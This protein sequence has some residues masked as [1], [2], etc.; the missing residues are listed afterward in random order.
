[1]PTHTGLVAWLGEWLHPFVNGLT[2]TEAVTVLQPLAL[3][4]LVMAA[5]AVFV[6]ELYHFISDKDIFDLSFRQYARG[7]T[8]KM[9]NVFRGLLYV[10][11][12]LVVYPLLVVIW[13]LVFAGFLSFLAKG[14]TTNTLLLAS[15]AFVSTVRIAA[16]YHK[17]LAE[18]LAKMLPLAL[19]GIFLTDV[20]S[21]SFDQGV[22]YLVTLP[23][24]ATKIIYYAAFTILLEF[25]LRMFQIL[26]RGTL[27]TPDEEE[28]AEEQ[29][30]TPAGN[31][32]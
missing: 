11:K 26:R 5:Y 3:F 9:K 7:K 16:Y 18:D 2:L 1:M 28:K 17:N 29:E 19:L 20:T 15:V 6:F 13:Y 25:V 23:D 8:E 21:F 4:T 12:Y 24:H 10:L 32:V 14:H 22:Q 27:E 31:V 30:T